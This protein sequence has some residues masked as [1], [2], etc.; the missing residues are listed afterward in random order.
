[1]SCSIASRSSKARSV[2]LPNSSSAE[3]R[4]A[5]LSGGFTFFAAYLKQRL[6]IDHVHA[7]QLHVDDDGYV[8]GDVRGPIVDGA[9]KAALLQQIAQQESI[10]MQQ[11]VAVG[12]GANDLPCSPS[13]AWA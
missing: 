1:M 4:Q 9:R 5:I 6:G 12:D 13:P 2:Y 7:N 11:V 3:Q 8:T 10:P